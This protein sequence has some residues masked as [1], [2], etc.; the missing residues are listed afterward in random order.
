[1]T[2]TILQFEYSLYN[3]KL[4]YEYILWILRHHRYQRYKPITFIHIFINIINISITTNPLSLVILF[5]ISSF[6]LKFILTSSDHY[7]NFIAILVLCKNG[8]KTDKS[9][10][11][12]SIEDTKD[13]TIVQNTANLLFL[14]YRWSFRS[15]QTCWLPCW[16]S[17]RQVRMIYKVFLMWKYFLIIKTSSADDFLPLSWLYQCNY[18]VKTIFPILLVKWHTSHLTYN[19]KFEIEIKKKL[20]TDCNN[21]VLAW[22]MTL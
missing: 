11:L 22:C 12:K 2:A 6:I 5:L 9:M 18:V 10:K 21:I 17:L 15:K 7:V 4:L 19:A 13:R 16:S 20:F 14:R 1:M 8:S 3:T